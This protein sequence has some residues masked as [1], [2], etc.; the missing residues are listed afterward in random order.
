LTRGNKEFKA[1]N[2]KRRKRE[3]AKLRRNKYK[4]AKAKEYACALDS[5]DKRLK[6]W[7][8]VKPGF[9]FV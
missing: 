2:T 8:A 7:F 4:K 6:P 9:C 5:V 1:N 3:H